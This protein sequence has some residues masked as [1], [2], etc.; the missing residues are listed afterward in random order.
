VKAL[1]AKPST[2]TVPPTVESAI[3]GH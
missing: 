1:C 2:T 3:T